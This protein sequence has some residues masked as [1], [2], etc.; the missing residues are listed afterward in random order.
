SPILEVGLTYRNLASYCTL[1]DKCSALSLAFSVIYG[2]QSSKKERTK[3]VFSSLKLHLNDVYKIAM[4]TVLIVKLKSCRINVLLNSHYER[5]TYLASQIAGEKLVLVQHGRL[6]EGITFV[7]KLGIINR[8]Y[9]YNDKSYK[10]YLNYYSIIR[11][12]QYIKPK[13]T[14]THI[15]DSSK[16]NIFIASS[17]VAVDKEIAFIKGLLALSRKLINIVVY[18]KLH[19]LYDYAHQ[20]DE[21]SDRVVFLDKN[22]Y[23]YADYMVTYNSALG[24]EYLA[25]EQRVLFLEEYES[26]EEAVELVLKSLIEDQKAFC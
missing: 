21:V 15:G 22:S 25:L 12:Y 2:V 7:H 11:D 26:I 5:W 17:I 4:Y 6:K 23:P 3:L 13:L 9:C 14:L 19:P 24:D 18:V 8:L 1:K 16:K 20:Y 10:A